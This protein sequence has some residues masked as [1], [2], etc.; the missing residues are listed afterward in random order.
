MDKNT[1]IEDP[2]FYNLEKFDF[3]L[4]KNSPAFKINFKEFDLP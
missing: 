2:L 4:K 3:R 1:I